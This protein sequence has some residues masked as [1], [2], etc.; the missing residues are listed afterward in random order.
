MR[1]HFAHAAFAALLFGISTLVNVTP[2]HATQTA[3]EIRSLADQGDADA[4][5]NLAVL[6][7]SG[8]GVAQDW[9]EAAHWLRLAADQ[10]H[11]PGQSALGLVYREGLG[12]QPDLVEAVRWVRRGA[13]QGDVSGQF[14]LASMYANGQG[15]PLDNMEA[16]MW[17]S[18]AAAQSSGENRVTYEA[19][20]D[21]VEARMTP[22]QI[23]EAQRRAR[24]WRPT[25]EP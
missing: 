24:E 3:E 18:L 4:Q 17:L 23:A 8:Q 19:S 14:L 15:V 11:A 6:Y 1:V 21:T 5:F 13:D 25:I 12:V 22:D 16:F 20:R 10:G 2:L 9:T 7:G